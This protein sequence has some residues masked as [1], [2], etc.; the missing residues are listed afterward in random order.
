MPSC[1]LTQQCRSLFSS[2]HNV[3]SIALR[4][5]LTDIAAYKWI[6]TQCALMHINNAILAVTSI[7]LLFVFVSSLFVRC[8][9]LIFPLWPLLLTICTIWSKFI[10]HL[11]LL[12]SFWCA[13]A[14]TNIVI[15]GNWSDVIHH[16]HTSSATVSAGVNGASCCAQINVMPRTQEKMTVK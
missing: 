16:R 8:T 7:T 6:T 1:T 5:R 14:S 12:L 11:Q 10:S 3:P 9:T 15:D 2:A 13:T 4:P